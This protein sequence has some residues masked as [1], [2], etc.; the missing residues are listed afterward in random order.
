MVIDD[1]TLNAVDSGLLAVVINTVDV[2][3]R[4]ALVELGLF[5]VSEMPQ[6]IPLARHL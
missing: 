1:R 2:L 5:L 3:H 4:H 6:S